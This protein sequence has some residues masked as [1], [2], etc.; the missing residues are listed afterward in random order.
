MATGGTAVLIIMEQQEL[1][2]VTI[3]AHF[4]QPGTARQTAPDRTS[5]FVFLGFRPW[6]QGTDYLLGSQHI[7]RDCSK[8]KIKAV[9]LHYVGVKERKYSSYSFL[10]STLHGVGWQRHVPSALYTRQKKPGT[11]W[12]GGWVGLTAGL[13]TEAKGNTLCFCQGS[14]PVRP[15]CSQT[16][17]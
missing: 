16:L 13:D 11:H 9:P 14:N 4:F 10:T 15:D 5:T 6:L 17:C 1:P 12:I 3:C 7:C 2:H 8:S